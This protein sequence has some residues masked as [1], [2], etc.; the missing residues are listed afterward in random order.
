MTFRGNPNV[1]NRTDAQ[2]VGGKKT[3]TSD[4]ELFG[5][6]SNKSPSLT[7]NIPNVKYTRLIETSNGLTVQ[8]GSGSQLAQIFAAGTT[9]TNS[10]ITTLS[11]TKGKVGGQKISTGVVINWGTTTHSAAAVTVTFSKPFSGTNYAVTAVLQTDTAS[12][13]ERYC[14]IVYSKTTTGCTIWIK[15][16]DG[17]ISWNAI[18][19]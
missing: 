2:D 3:H 16:T 19:Y 1:V 18:G 8:D 15:G 9:E 7:F 10:C 12:T 6:I 5:N 14:P 4:V 11:V 13:V 17:N